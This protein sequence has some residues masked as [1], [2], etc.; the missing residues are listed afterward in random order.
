MGYCQ[1]IGKPVLVSLHAAAAQP[2][3]RLGQTKALADRLN[4][5][6]EASVKLAETCGAGEFLVREPARVS[7]PTH[8]I[9][10]G[11]RSASHRT[12]GRWYWQYLRVSC[13]FAEGATLIQH[14]H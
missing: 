12:M 10:S 4:A 2:M 14:W 9:A 7:F 5:A 8:Q 3:P 13:R 6:W 1:A 11:A